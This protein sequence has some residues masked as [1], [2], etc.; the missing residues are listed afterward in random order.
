MTG[1]HWAETLAMAE[2][3]RIRAV[4]EHQNV[5]GGIALMLLAIFVFSVNDALGKW[6]AG[7]Y[8]VGQILLFRSATALVVLVPLIARLG[9]RPFLAVERPGLQV[10]RVL[11]S[12]GETACFYIAV[13]WLPL[14][15][16]MTYYMAAPIFV[17]VLAAVILGERV[18]WR[19]WGAVLVGFVGVVLALQPSAG[20]FGWPVLI[21]V[22]G[23]ALFSFLMIATRSLRATPNAVL[24]TWQMVGSLIFGVVVAPF[25]WLPI[26][27]LDAGLLG[28]VGVVAMVA[29]A[30]VNW[31][32]KLAP[33]SV[34]VPYQYTLIIWAAIFGYLVFGDFPALPVVAGAALIVGAGVFILL[35]ERQVLREPRDD[36]L[37]ER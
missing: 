20:A 23:S 19:R 24:V 14:A 33:A 2:I 15:D 6:L 25:Q 30:G 35:R 37:A 22:L 7:T 10:T 34:V 3:T 17:T 29:I 11:L 1:A 28:L 4:A 36:L 21:A 16:T 9:P 18:G 5:V 27:W 31:S 8:L 26:S 32:L 13:R 12:T